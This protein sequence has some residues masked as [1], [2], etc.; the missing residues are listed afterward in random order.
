[1]AKCIIL[2]LLIIEISVAFANNCA[3]DLIKHYEGFRS[4]EYL[5]SGGTR[6]IG[7]GET[8]YTKSTITRSE[9]EALVINRV[10][11]F[12]L[13]SISD[14]G[15]NYYQEC[16]VISFVYNVGYGNFKRSTMYKL[17][18][19]NKYKQAA[20]EFD[21]W[22]YVKGKKVNG[23]VTRRLNERLIFEE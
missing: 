2:I 15:L 3:I 13:S 5:D 23:L 1:M 14:L 11:S 19:N 20:K 12:P 4:T 22:V 9:A 7:Y 8:H 16:A 10:Y 6:T 18:K 21:K 17:L